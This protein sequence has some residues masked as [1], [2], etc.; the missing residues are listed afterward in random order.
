MAEDQEVPD[1]VVLTAPI[2][3]PGGAP[4]AAD[5][6]VE[7]ATSTVPAPV[8]AFGRDV[9]R[10]AGLVAQLVESAGVLGVRLDGEVRDVLGSRAPSRCACRC[11][12]GRASRPRSRSGS[13]P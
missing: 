7:R 12:P 5:E 11:R 8:G 6:P 2:R 10:L 3:L 4:V 13:R 9:E 1:D